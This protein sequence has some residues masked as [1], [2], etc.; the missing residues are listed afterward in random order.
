MAV[1]MQ[2]LIINAIILSNKLTKIFH[3]IITRIILAIYWVREKE[4]RKIEK[5]VR[6]Y[7][8]QTYYP[9]VTHEILICCAWFHFVAGGIRP[10]QCKSEEK[11]NLYHPMSI[12]DNI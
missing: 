5:Y 12:Y 7:E 8:S 6:I 3:N 4:T 1:T 9:A 10:L 11:Q 2:Q